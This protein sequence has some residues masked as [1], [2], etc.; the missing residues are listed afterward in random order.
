MDDDMKRILTEFEKLQDLF[1]EKEK[2]GE[3][4]CGFKRMVVT[5]QDGMLL[6]RKAFC[7]ST[8]REISKMIFN[9]KKER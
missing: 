3:C 7:I 6:R 8:F 2:R 4:D 9:E 5:R 1:D